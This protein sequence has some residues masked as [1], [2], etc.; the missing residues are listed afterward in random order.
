MKKDCFNCKH[1]EFEPNECEYSSSD[2]GFICSKREETQ[3][4]IDNIAKESYLNKAKVCC[5]LK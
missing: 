2:G 4:L 3:S 1:L 5:D